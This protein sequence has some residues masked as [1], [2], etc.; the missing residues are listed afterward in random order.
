MSTTAAPDSVFCPDCGT[1]TP[2][3]FC[4]SCGTEVPRAP[5][6]Q[7]PS[8]TQPPSVLPSEPAPPGRPRWLPGALVGGAVLAIMAIVAA[9]LIALTG[10]SDEPKTKQVS[11]AGGLQAVQLAGQPLYAPTQSDAFVVLMPAGWA[12][13]KFAAPISL[14]G[15]VTA[16][17]PQDEATSISVG[18]IRRDG[19]LAAQAKTID[20]GLSRKQGFT[21]GRSQGTRLPGGVPGWRITYQLG[22]SEQLMYLVDY[23]DRRFAIIGATSPDKAAQ[24]KSR[25]SMTAGTLQVTC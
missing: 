23:C 3:R 20:A 8:T 1:P 25:F 7:A 6:Q 16:R 9:G 14:S 21:S 18:E 19:K 24:V 12:P 10:S 13:G 22:N 11:P 4:P 17:S 5:T 15:Q 2:G